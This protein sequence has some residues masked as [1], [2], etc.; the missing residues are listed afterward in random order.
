MLVLLASDGVEALRMWSLKVQLPR[1]PGGA[2][3]A[4]RG[5]RRFACARLHRRHTGAADRARNRLVA[6]FPLFLAFRGCEKNGSANRHHFRRHLCT[7][8]PRSRARPQ[9][10]RGSRVDARRQG[11]AR[12]RQDRRSRAGR[13]RAAGHDAG[14]IRARRARKAGAA[15]QGPAGRFHT[16]ADR[17]A[18]R[19]TSPPRKPFPPIRSNTPRG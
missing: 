12:P 13:D 1:A 6:V 11:G 14:E 18:R 7:F 8:A 15:L 17:L 5:A 19:R 9:A 2:R 3:S 10:R 16:A 4:K